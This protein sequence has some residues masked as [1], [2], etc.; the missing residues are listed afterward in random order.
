MDPITAGYLSSI[1]ASATLKILPKAG[2]K[3]R[4]AILG[5][6]KEQAF[7]R[8]MKNAVTSTLATVSKQVGDKLR[9]LADFL[10]LFLEDEDV[11]S[12]LAALLRGNEPEWDILQESL[13]RAGVKQEHFPDLDAA[14]LLQVFVAAFNEST[15]SEPDLQGIIQTHAIREQTQ[16]QR[17]IL[18]A[19]QT[20]LDFL[21]QTKPESV[22]LHAG[23]IT[24]TSYERDEQITYQIPAL[25]KL[26]MK[27]RLK[28]SGA[29]VQGQG[30]KG[31]GARGFVA[32]DVDRSIV[33]TGDVLNST[34]NVYTSPPG[35]HTLSKNDFEKMLNEYMRWVTKA[36]SHA[37]LFGLESLQPAQG[38]VPVRKLTDVFV[39]V[40][41][42]RFQP[43]DRDK[44]EQIFDKEGD[45]LAASKAYLKWVEETKEKGEQVELRNL[46]LTDKRIAIIGGAGTGKSTVLA[47]LATKLAAATTGA[48]DL[49]FDL[50]AQKRLP[51]PLVIPL[52]YYREYLRLLEQAPQARLRHPQTGQ[53]AHFISWHLRKRSPSLGRC[54]DFFERLLLGGGC[55]LMLDGLDE[56]AS[57]D[58][59]GLVRQQVENIANDM[60]PDNRIIVTAREAGYQGNAV[61]GDDF[62]RL[63]VQRLTDGQIRALISNWCCQLFPGEEANRTDEL[64]DEVRIINSLRTDRDLP[65]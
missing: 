24:G 64:M 49:P 36:Y 35:K 32:D 29:N 37:R 54:E 62:A 1:A 38:G 57:R 44:R 4:K 45:V 3:I 42:R 11:S 55:L 5:T 2:G 27:A 33:V 43:I 50:P 20:I 61:F 19:I 48:R 26:T 51:V 17:E 25:P 7:Q 34:F 21:K 16:L 9:L 31:A 47:Y 65:H 30:A 15:A 52:R 18:R 23:Q 60:Y 41:L 58:E 53:L 8:A 46:L 63:D 40:K 59:R 13:E 22:T 14:V 6:E 28:G 56:I 10:N 12:E 39:P